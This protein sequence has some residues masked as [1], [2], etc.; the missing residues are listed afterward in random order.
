MAKR[1]VVVDQDRCVGCQSCVFACTRR[2]GR[3]GT[4]LSCL[5]VKSAGGIRKGYQAVI[6]RACP[7]PSCARACPVDALAVREGGGVKLS[8]DVCIGCGRCREAC[9]FGAVFWDADEEKPQICVY[10]GYCA[11]HC[12]Y[13]V[14]VLGDTEEP[15]ED[16][17]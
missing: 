8:P 15:W 4:G 14:F 3:G 2:L 11:R 6:C 16:V 12:P 9:P 7:D 1:L 13:E 10:C 5:A 17:A